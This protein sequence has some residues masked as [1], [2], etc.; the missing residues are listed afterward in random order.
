MYTYTY[1]HTKA[2]RY[3]TREGKRA[4]THHPNRLQPCCGT[5]R[6]RAVQ[7]G[8]WESNAAGPS[9]H[10]D[11]QGSYTETHV[12]GARRPEQAALPAL[13]LSPRHR[14]TVRQGC[15]ACRVRHPRLASI[16]YAKSRPVSRARARAGRKSAPRATGG[17]GRFRRPRDGPLLCPE[18]Q[19]RAWGAS[20]RGRAARTLLIFAP[21]AAPTSS[22]AEPAQTSTPRCRRSA[23]PRLR[24]R[25]RRQPA[26][27]AWAEGPLFQA[28]DVVDY[29]CVET[30]WTH[31]D[32]PDAWG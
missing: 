12:V 20:A 6:A 21:R 7:Q 23:C 22:S 27:A 11:A 9:S 31:R 5:R 19:G 17:L 8:G 15:H 4:A 16:Q 30:V 14:N 29:Q 3:R 1:Q 2:R 28:V 24:R 26:A 13:P 25:G 10:A 32:A 18:S